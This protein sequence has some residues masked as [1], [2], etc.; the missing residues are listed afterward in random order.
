[1]FSGLAHLWFG[2]G[3]LIVDSSHLLLL[4][5]FLLPPPPGGRMFSSFRLAYVFS[6]SCPLVLGYWVLGF[7]CILCL[8]SLC[9]PL[10]D[11]HPSAV[12][13]VDFVLFVKGSASSLPWQDLSFSW[14]LS[15]PEGALRN[16]PVGSPPLE[17][18]LGVPG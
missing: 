4:S 18:V 2:V 17:G 9:L 10:L 8:F 7:A 11:T 3:S 5:I 13:R 1:M 6:C 14:P 16:G 12:S 15:V